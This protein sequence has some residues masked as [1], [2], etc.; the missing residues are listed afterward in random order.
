MK[1]QKNIKT[2]VLLCLMAAVLV[3]LAYTPLGY[4]NIGPLAIT[5]NTIPVAIAAIALGPVGGIVAGGVFG[6]TSF[7]QCFGGS[8]LGTTLFGISPILTVFQCFVP[9][10]LDGLLIGLLSNA[11]RKHCTSAIANCA[12]TGFFAAFLNTLF[13]MSSLILLFGRTDII[14]SYRETRAPGQNVFL[15][16]CAFV[17]INAIAEWVS[18]TLVTGAVGAALTKAKLVPAPKAKLVAAE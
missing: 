17:G 16:V 12:V 3:I 15:F 1:S 13:Y 11:M 2:M 8:V 7:L 6:L 9:R 10:M 14:L 18:S 5:F 4:L